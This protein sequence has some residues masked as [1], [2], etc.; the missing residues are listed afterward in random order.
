[1][2]IK[3]TDLEGKSI[4]INADKIMWITPYST[5]G[6]A[7]ASIVDMGA[8]AYVRVSESPDVIVKLIERRKNGKT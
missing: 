5:K 7:E 6:Y 8:D 2:F 4:F 3:L 1:M